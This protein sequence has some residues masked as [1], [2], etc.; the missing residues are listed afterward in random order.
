MFFSHFTFNTLT[1][2]HHF[3]IFLLTFSIYRFGTGLNSLIF[4]LFM[5]NF[6]AFWF[7]LTF[8]WIWSS[9]D[10]RASFSYCSHLHFSGHCEIS[11]LTETCV[12]IGYNLSAV[13]CLLLI[14]RI[15]FKHLLNIKWLVLVHFALYMTV[16]HKTCVR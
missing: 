12:V 1:N 6:L 10:L 2:L 7:D 14:L 9:R 8:S 3:L 4:I 16:H 11:V 15:K 13:L 5:D